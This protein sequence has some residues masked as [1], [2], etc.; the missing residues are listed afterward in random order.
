MIL[1]TSFNNSSQGK[2]SCQGRE[3]SHAMRA[4]AKLREIREG[5]IG[6]G[7]DEEQEDDAGRDRHDRLEL[8]VFD[9]GNLGLA[10]G[11]ELFAVKGDAGCGGDRDGSTEHTHKKHLSGMI[12]TPGIV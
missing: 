7:A 3:E 8:G 4:T 5:V 6:Y 2:A 12:V 1:I 10:F 9:A 11:F